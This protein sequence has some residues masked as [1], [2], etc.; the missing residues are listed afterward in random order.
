MPA[1]FYAN[2]DRVGRLRLMADSQKFSQYCRE[3]SSIDKSANKNKNHFLRKITLPVIEIT[4]IRSDQCLGRKC[5]FR[6]KM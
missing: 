3:T 4:S 5:N 1:L 6:F 2:F